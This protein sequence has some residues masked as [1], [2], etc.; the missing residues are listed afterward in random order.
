[1]NNELIDKMPKNSLR[2]N[3]AEFIGKHYDECIK[4]KTVL[5]IGAAIPNKKCWWADNKV[6]FGTEAKEWLATDMQVA[7]N[8]DLVL[9]MEF[10]GEVKTRK[11]NNKFDTIVAIETFEH[12]FHY[13]S[14][15]LN[16]FAA[17]KKGGTLLVTLPFG[18]PVHNFPYDYFRYT[19]EALLRIFSDAGFKDIEVTETNF[20]SFTVQQYSD[21][22]ELMSFPVQVMLKAVKRG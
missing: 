9:D 16:C 1:M 5:E 14:V 22:F 18:H 21:E 2:K 20:K 15:A 12:V 7:P 8:I 13:N 10:V 4:D 11:L 3:I 17:L 6:L 19:P